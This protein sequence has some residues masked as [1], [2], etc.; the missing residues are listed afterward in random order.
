MSFPVR[1]RAI[2]QRGGH[3]ALVVTV[4]VLSSWASLQ[5]R[6]RH[7]RRNNGD[8]GALTTEQ[9][10]ITTA[11]IGLAGLL[12]VALTAFVQKKLPRIR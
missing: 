9:A 1:P 4:L 2:R 11:L 5:A 3:L 6:A 8:R 7:P 10:I 12:V